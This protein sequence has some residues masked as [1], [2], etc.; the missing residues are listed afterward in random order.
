M[1][2]LNI[3]SIVEDE[4]HRYLHRL[5]KE[6]IRQKAKEGLQN[7]IRDFSIAAI[8]K[9]DT[10]SLQRPSTIYLNPG[11]VVRYIERL[12][13]RYD[14]LRIMHPA[15]FH[16]EICLF[17]RIVSRDLINRKI[18]INGTK[19][20]SLATRIVKAMKYTEVR[21][22]VYPL[23]ARKL[24]LKTC[25]YCNANY[26]ISD[27]AGNGYYDLDH[28]K[29]KSLYPYLC[30]S[31]YNIQPSCPSCNRRKSDNDNLHFMNLWNDSGSMN[32]EIFRF[33]LNKLSAV[34]Y[35]I[36]MD[37]KKLSISIKSA[38]RRA[39]DIVS[40]TE[41]RLHLQDRYNEHRDVVEEILWKKQIYNDS[42]LKQ[43]IESEI[44]GINNVDV[45]RFILGTYPGPEDIHKRPLS[46]LILDIAQQEGLI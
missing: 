12:L 2:Q 34:N 40:D 39:E 5:D 43:I 4:A 29:A 3:T 36:D 6:G 21:E 32:N 31:F 22:T 46:K 19:G 10:G 45:K 1:V 42:F 11:M 16:H 35:W 13:R 8:F 41:S 18:T 23:S 30:T 20:D 14:S 44:F 17:E 9:I 33:K 26:T 28:W 24:Q 15:K 25:V 38:Q 37:V 27:H 7:I